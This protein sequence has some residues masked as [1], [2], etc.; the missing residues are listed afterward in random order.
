MEE[1]IVVMIT[2]GSEEEGAKIAEVLLEGRLI[3][4]ANLIGGIRSLYR[5]EGKVCDDPEILLVCKTV[6]KH[7]A[8]LSE[9]VKSVHSYDVPEIIALPVV[10]GYPPYLEWV[11]QE[12]TPE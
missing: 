4:C 2:A 6:R 12:T 9:K 5:W 1:E 7:F 11:E 3:A 10:E 8:A